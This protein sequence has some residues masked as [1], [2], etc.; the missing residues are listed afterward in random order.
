[1]R[2]K[3]KGKRR[4]ASFQ[5]GAEASTLGRLG[6]RR[7]WGYCDH[8][9]AYQPR[10]RGHRCAKMTHNARPAAPT[11][12]PRYDHARAHVLALSPE[13]ASLRRPCPAAR[14]RALCAGC[15]GARAGPARHDRRGPARA[16]TRPGTAG[17][18]RAACGRARDAA[19]AA[20]PVH[21]LPARA[22]RRRPGAALGPPAGPRGPASRLGARVET[23]AQ[24]VPAV[25]PVSLQ[26][27]MFSISEVW[28]PAV[29]LNISD[30]VR[31]R[32]F[33]MLHEAVHFALRDGGL[34]DLDQEDRVADA[35]GLADDNS[36]ELRGKARSV[37]AD[38]GS[39]G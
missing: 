29:I 11:G 3:T 1:M 13:A 4:G 38:L 21:V 36:V 2:R 17:P 22:Q 19:L 18:G 30:P 26:I 32:I 37:R 9:N 16:G 24:A 15:A 7:R 39:R 14:R 25:T 8:C 34:C 23:L 35:W 10:A 33:T 20:T 31:P 12:W 5:P 28:L 27:G 6:A